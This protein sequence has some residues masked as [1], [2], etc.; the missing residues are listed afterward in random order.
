LSGPLF[1]EISHP[2]FLARMYVSSNDLHE[3]RSWPAQ[4]SL[5]EMICCDGVEEILAAVVNCCPC[6]L[7]TD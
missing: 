1:W 6:D 4:V 7:P 5:S 2:D 3:Q